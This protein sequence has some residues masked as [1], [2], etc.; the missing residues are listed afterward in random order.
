MLEIT[1]LVLFSPATVP[2][3]TAKQKY[4]TCCL[5][6]VEI[7]EAT[8]QTILQ[9]ACTT[10][11]SVLGLASSNFPESK[12]QYYLKYLEYKCLTYVLYIKLPLAT[13][14][15]HLVLPSFGTALDD[16]IGYCEFSLMLLW[17]R[18]HI[19]NGCLFYHIRG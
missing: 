10:T 5:T 16:L 13:S 14:F 3:I 12:Y 19:L 4:N 7:M 17:V 2:S 9:T 8:P 18:C 11:G 1:E 6:K 15:E